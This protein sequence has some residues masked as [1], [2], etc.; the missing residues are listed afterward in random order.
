MMVY[1]MSGEEDLPPF[2]HGGCLRRA[3]AGPPAVG[4]HR[5]GAFMSSPGQMPRHVEES[6]GQGRP[7][8]M[9]LECQVKPFEFNVVSN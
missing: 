4:S 1:Q 2:C 7:V 8:L 3:P 9:G 5:L 6:C